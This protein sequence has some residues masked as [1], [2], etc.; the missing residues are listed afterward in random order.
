VRKGKGETRK[1]AVGVLGEV[2]CGLGK[3]R[4][5]NIGI[6]KNEACAGIADRLPAGK[7]LTF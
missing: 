7:N 5:L 2:T 3:E 1:A 4:G 6:S